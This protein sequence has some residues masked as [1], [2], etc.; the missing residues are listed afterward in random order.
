LV[1]ASF[2]R[3]WRILANLMNA[4]ASKRGRWRSIWSALPN[5]HSFFD[6][7]SEHLTVPARLGIAIERSRRFGDV[8]LALALWR[9]IGLEDLCDDCFLSGRNALPGRRRRPCWWRR[10]SASRRANGT[11]Q[12]IVA[13]MEAGHGMLGRVW[14]TDRGMANAE[15]P[16][17][18]RP[19][20]RP[21]VGGAML[22]WGNCGRC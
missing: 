11:L 7:G 17:W 19:V 18:L 21:A 1:V 15:N 9:G 2:S 14:I 12:T 13:T 10:G 5:A 22:T 16:A 4:V 20:P 3:L 8:H 6:D